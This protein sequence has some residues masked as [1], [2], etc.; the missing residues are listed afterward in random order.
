MK[1]NP[2]AV[3]GSVLRFLI[4]LGHSPALIQCS[5]PKFQTIFSFEH[6]ISVPVT[7]VTT[8]YALV[9]LAR[10]QEG[11]SVLIHSAAGGV[12]QFAIQIAQM[13]GAT[14]YATVG[15]KEKKHFL[16]E[17]YGIPE[18]HILSSRNTAFAQGVMRL[19]GAKGVDVIFNSLSGELVTASWDFIAS[20]GRF[21]EI[22]KEHIER[23]RAFRK[24]LFAVVKMLA[25]HR[26]PIK[27]CIPGTTVLQVSASKNYWF[28]FF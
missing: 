2:A 6:A 23:P 14:I 20:F 5:S 27:G 17:R 19:T 3:A 4:T 11:E 8:H 12:G 1:I 26:L 28:P 16:M 13:I 9:E 21:I 18:D 22:G 7:G 10:L 25:E 15:T 24:S